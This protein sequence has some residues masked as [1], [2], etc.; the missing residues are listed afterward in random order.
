MSKLDGINTDMSGKIGKYVYRRTKKGTV[1]AQAPRKYV[2]PRRSEQQ[3]YLRCQMGNAAANFRLFDDML[4]Q[5]FEEKPEG[6]SDFNMFV[7]T[8]YGKNPVFITQDMRLEGA[9]VVAP[10]TFCRGSLAAVGY[11]LNASGVAVTDIKLGTLV[12]G[13]ETT[14]AELTIA[15]MRNNRGWQDQ[16]QLTFFYAE[17]SQDASGMPRA[18]MFSQKVVLDVSDETPL[19]EVADALGF[20]TVDG[21]LGMG[22]ALTSGGTAWVHSRDKQGGQTKVST[23][24]M[25]VVNPILA[26]YQTSAAMKASADSYGGVNSKAVYLNPKN[27]GT[28]NFAGYTS[29]NSGSASQSGSGSSSS[30]GQESSGGSSGTESSETGGESGGGNGTSTPGE[31]D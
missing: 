14:V 29:G 1:V 17:Q 2:V 15:V 20:S 6:T 24:K 7:K 18:T 9:C 4:E 10:Y 5:A 25:L 11:E 12:I 22:M 28:G 19:T 16:D 30:G 13:E 3:M 23:Q 8:N 26:Q 27:Q 21:H 31:G